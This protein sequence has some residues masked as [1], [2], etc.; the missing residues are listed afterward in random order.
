MARA[1]GVIAHP[2]GG[3][4]RGRRRHGRGAAHEGPALVDCLTNRM[5]LAMPPSTTIEQLKGFGLYVRK[6]VL[7][8]RG[9]EVLEL[10]RS[11]LWR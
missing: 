11:N 6:A 4:G 5:E 1:M 8:G 9:D 7:N 3:P 10:A 2:G